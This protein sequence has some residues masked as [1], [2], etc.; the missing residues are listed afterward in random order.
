MAAGEAYELHP[1]HDLVFAN[2]MLDSFDA[3]DAR[4]KVLRSAAGLPEEPEGDPLLEQWERCA[5]IA[6][7][8]CG[9]CGSPACSFCM[10]AADIRAVASNIPPI[11]EVQPIDDGLSSTEFVV[12]QFIE[13]LCANHGGFSRTLITAYRERKPEL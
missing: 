9:A 1:D 6:E 3:A 11:D 12:E 10:V 2:A 8:R 7:R 13:T 4:I 5:G